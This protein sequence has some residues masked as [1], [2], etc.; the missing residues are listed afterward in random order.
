[1]CQPLAV[2]ARA[3]TGA[4]DEVDG[5]G[6]D[7]PDTDAAQHIFAAPPLE[8]RIGD[9][10]I[11]EQLAQQQPRR[12]GADDRDLR[13]HL[14]PNSRSVGFD[15]SILGEGCR[16]DNSDRGQRR[17]GFDH[18]TEELQMPGRPGDIRALPARCC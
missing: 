13:A 11:V 17:R 8:D 7:E 2:K 6:L 14:F 9:A 1:M 10:V 16:N 4:V 12:A 3:D 15:F 5:A 18:G